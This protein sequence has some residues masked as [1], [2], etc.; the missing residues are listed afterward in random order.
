VASTV[1]GGVAALKWLVDR[2][3]AA[4][5]RVAR[6]SEERYRLLFNRSRAGCYQSTMDGRLLDCNDSLARILGYGSRAECLERQ[7]TE[8]YADPRERE[9]FLAALKEHG[10]LS[11]FENRLR[12][13]DGRPVW[14]LENASLL[15]SQDGLPPI[16][17]GT[18]IDITSRKEAEAALHQAME[19]AEAANRAKSEFL[20]NMSHEIR[21]PMNGIVGMTE[22]ALGTDLTLEQREY[23]EMVQISS[24]S[25]LSLINDILDFSKIEARKLNLDVVGF[26]LGRVL[27]DLMRTLAPR[28]H[29]KGLELAYHV[30]PE[31]PH[32]LDGDPARLSQIILNLVS[33]AVKFT[34]TGEVVVRVGCEQRA[35]DRVNLHFAV[36][37][38]GIGIPADKH[39]TIFDAFTQA[40]AST[41]R[42]FGGTGLGLAIASQLTILMGG[43]ISLESTSGLGSTFHVRLAFTVST[44][45]PMLVPARDASEL[46]GMRVL[47]VDD[48]ETNRDLLFRRLTRQGYAVAV[49]EHGRQALER[50]AAEE[51]NSA[52]ISSGRMTCSSSSERFFSSSICLR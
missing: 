1:T 46:H 36:S 24:D 43:K 15:E 30:A 47:V 22:L 26:D 10:F 6:L 41:T 25:L 48:N 3:M 35:G 18:L 33:N 16:I 27:D 37:D 20:A 11:D 19:A 44:G 52:T 51:F 38:T 7:V 45:R 4:Q 32:A 49:A 21:T 17:E 9:P 50:I 14:V 8:V 29:Q 28:A 23:L 34:E 13:R 39:A 40:D 31:V 5:A 2:R 42:R 12:R